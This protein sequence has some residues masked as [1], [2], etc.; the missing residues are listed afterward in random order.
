[1]GTF[2]VTDVQNMVG[3]NLGTSNATLE[4]GIE[5]VVTTSATK[6]IASY[7]GN[8]TTTYNINGNYIE[9]SNDGIETITLTVNS[10]SI[11][12]KASY[13]FYN[14][15]DTFTSFTITVPTTCDYIVLVGDA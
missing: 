4:V 3:R 10:I 9:I 14:T 1:M 11:A 12:I 5:G 13:I 6:I 8:T 7:T 2:S 15:F